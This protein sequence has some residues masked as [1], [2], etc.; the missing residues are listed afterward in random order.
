MTANR[1]QHQRT[2][3]I[4]IDRHFFRDLVALGHVQVLHVPSHYQYA[5]IFT[6]GLSTTLF[7]DFRSSLNLRIAP[8]DKS[9][10]GC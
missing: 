10:L 6:K 7:T 1:V 4:K 8:S 2:K 3:H 9:A 5:D